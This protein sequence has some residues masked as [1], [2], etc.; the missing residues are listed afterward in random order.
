MNS[1]TAAN[2]NSDTAAKTFTLKDLQK[3]DWQNGNPSAYV[4]VNGKVYNVTIVPQRQNGVHHG[5]KAGN[6]LSEAV[7][8]AP[9]G[10]SVLDQVPV[11]GELVN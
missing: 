11:I 8:S 6:D 4:T 10:L 7:K 5:F 1:D 9:H 3:Y 2:T